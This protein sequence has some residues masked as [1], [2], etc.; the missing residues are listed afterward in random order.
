MRL[1]IE[2]STTSGVSFE[3]KDIFTTQDGEWDVSGKPFSLPQWARDAYLSREFDDAG[4]ATHI[5]CR[6]EDESGKPIDTSITF[7]ANDQPSVTS[8]TGEKHS[9]WANMPLYSS[10]A[11][12][13]QSGQHG[14]WAVQAGNGDKVTGIGLPFRWHVSTFIVW[15][16]KSN[17]VRPDGGVIQVP[18]T[19]LQEVIRLL[20]SAAIKFRALLP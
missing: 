11:Y 3:I 9:M 17:A 8:H 20:E 2:P 10:S 13:P 19:E 6:V 14:I 12:D 15:R 18:I 16:R 1:N 4:A 7:F 5:L